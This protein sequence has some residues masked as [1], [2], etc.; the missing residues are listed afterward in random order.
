MHFLPKKVSNLG[1]GG[2]LPL[3]SRTKAYLRCELLSSEPQL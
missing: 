2:L 3:T 1:K